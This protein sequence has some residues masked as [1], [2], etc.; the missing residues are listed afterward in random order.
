MA[1]TTETTIPGS[2]LFGVPAP[3]D[4][5]AGI[6][7]PVSERDVLARI[8]RKIANTR[9]PGVRS[10]I[11]AGATYLAQLVAHDLDYAG[12]GRLDLGI[13]Y[14]DGPRR[15]A[16]CYQ[17][18]QERGTGRHLLRVGRTRTREHL[19][20]WGPARD[21]PRAACP[22]L[23]ARPGE[24]RSEV[25][26]PN[27]LSDSNLLLGQMHLLWA[28]AH[29]AV[30]A[31]LA[32]VAGTEAAFATA[33]RITRSIYRDVVRHDVLGCWL[34]PELRERYTAAR[35]RL[36][37]ARLRR[38]PAPE[39]VAGVGRLGHV[40]VR[41]VYAL[42]DRSAA[43]GLRS[44]MRHTS[45]GR[46]HEMPLTAD[47]LVDFSGFFAIAGSTPQ[48]A[49]AL[50][51]HVARALATGVGDAEESA[52]GGLVLRDLV[53]SCTGGLHSVRSL[54][55][56][57]R[58]ADPG[59][60]DGCFA[61]DESRW[62]AA[63]AT[64]LGDTGL[65]GEEIGRLAADPP[66]VLFLMLEAEADADG[67]WLGALGS[68]IMGETLAGAM[69]EEVDCPMLAD[70]RR[71]VFR[72]PAPDSAE[73]LVQFLQGHYRFPDDARLHSA[74]PPPEKPEAFHFTGGKA[75]FDIQAVARTPLPRVEVADYIELGRLVAQWATEPASRPASLD[76][77][78]SQLDGIAVLPPSVR[79]FEFTEAT[80]DHL[81]LRLPPS[82]V[83]EAEIERATDPMADG[84][85]PLPQFY[86]DHYRPGFG[87]VMTAHDTLL[88]R[89][90]EQAIAQGS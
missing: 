48:H 76:D 43:V 85:Y 25:L 6:A 78:R 42:N 11:P 39:F 87:P 45:T 29:N 13:V 72:G 16:S 24:G 49:R 23:D 52:E 34:A 58:A 15:D 14:G 71:A 8:A 7:D 90:G 46:P 65:T 56:R 61:G 1:L 12:A 10:A 35:P 59:L 55:R 32:P 40:L 88:A 4:R 31:A 57:V 83:V 5:F 36:L 38:G 18:P 50:G 2:N 53:A 60:L 82:E 63:L 69:P 37:D 9:R 66:L 26:V 19:P 68:V 41:E 84:R 51:P 20:V 81:V 86:A 79:S 64:W 28:L 22:H 77:L 27:E 17:V 47:W 33:R 62:R 30:A 89:V 73:R 70:A 80:L 67:R 54:V 21:L 74:A 44:L 3:D 75:M